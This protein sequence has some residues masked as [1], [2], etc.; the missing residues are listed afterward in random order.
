MTKRFA[1]VQDG[2]VVNLV[3]ADDEYAAEQGWIFAPDYVDGHA[4]STKWLYNGSTFIKP[5]TPPE[6]TSE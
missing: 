5:E 1:V 4:V 6:E 3:L 2:I